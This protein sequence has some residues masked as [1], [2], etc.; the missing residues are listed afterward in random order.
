MK[1]NV[2][3]FKFWIFVFFGVLTAVFF[4]QTVFL[5][6]IPAPTDSLVGLYHPWRDLYAATNPRGV[7]FKNFLITDPVRQQIPWRKVGIDLWK[8]GHIPTWNAY[9]FVGARLDSNIQAAVFYPLNILFLLFN[10]T[11]AW[12]ILIIVQPYVASLGLFF[13][14]RAHKRSLIASTFGAISWAFGGFSIAWLTWGTIMQSAMWLPIIL[15]SLDNLIKPKITKR[16]EYTWVSV[17]CVAIFLMMS[18]GHSQIALYGLLVAAL[19]ALWV[20]TQGRYSM[21]INRILLSRLMMLALLS[22]FITM[23]VWWPQVVT[24]AQTVRSTPQSHP[25]GWFLPWQHLFQFVAPDFFGN[26]ATLNYWGVWNYGEF[27]GYIGIIS[28]VFALSAMFSGSMAAF[29]SLVLLGALFFM[30][31]HPITSALGAMKI[32]LLGTLQ[33]TRLMMVAVLALCI[34]VAH[35]VDLWRSSTR[36][37]HVTLLCVGIFIVC[38]WIGAYVSPKLF[39]VS[40]ADMHVATRNLIIPTG[41][42]IAAVLLFFIN[43]FVPKQKQVYLLVI[44]LGISIVDLFRFGWKFTPYTDSKY[45]FPKT[46]IV[47]FLQ[48]Q[49]RP[50]RVASTDDRVF[51]PNSLSFY[52]IESIDGYDPLARSRYENFLTASERNKPDVTKPTGFNRIYTAKNISSALLPLFSAQYIISIDTLDKPWLSLVFQEGQ[53]K[54]YKNSQAFPRIYLADQIDVVTGG[55]VQHILAKLFLRI[56]QSRPAVVEESIPVLSLPLGVDESV[57]FTSYAAD[58]MRIESHTTNP[59]LL[60]VLNSYDEGWR[61]TIDEQATKLI[62]V[63]YLFF[64]LVVPAGSHEVKLFH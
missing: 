63:N 61:A 21:Q 26:P 52:D 3:R 55:D 14:L 57:E 20:Y 9:T 11:V 54:V 15:L 41:M 40:S 4:Y 48:K 25:I 2:H 6:K 5:G 17:G 46:K 22:C 43:T 47:E 59:R 60:V 42:F 18:A 19:Y 49:S 44:L 24:L 45:F 28:L 10:F 35:G 36:K 27:V 53:T 33:P 39:S 64:G 16:D 30:L 13:Y 62:R 50:Y 38:L 29:W 31:P 58:R 32:P 1:T 8:N 34:L 12:S 51:P 7:P 56:S 37:V 23:P